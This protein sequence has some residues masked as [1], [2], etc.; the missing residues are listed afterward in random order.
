MTV[1]SNFKRGKPIVQDFDAGAS[2]YAAGDVVVLGDLPCIAH[3]A[4]P[5]YTGGT[6]RDALAIGG[7]IYTVTAES[8]Q[9]KPG[10]RVYWDPTNSRVTANPQSG[11]NCVPFG[12]VVGLGTGL[13]SDAAATATTLDVFHDPTG[14]P[15]GSTYSLGA[16]TNDNITNTSAETA[17]AT[18]AVI[19]SGTLEVGDTIHVRAV[20]L[21]SAQN[22]TNTNTLKLKIT[23]AANTFTA[24]LNTGAVNAA[25]NAVA[26]LDA[27]IVI[28]AVGGSGSFY[29][30]GD[31]AFGASGTAARSPYY[32]ANTGLNTVE[33]I[34]VEVTDTQSAA[35]TGNVTQLVELMVEKLRK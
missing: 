8:A 22:S 34:T 3:S 33:A 20:A 2:T 12:W 28:T 19:P 17:F 21:V 7:G 32:V 10:D 31:I 18:T 6:T 5:S 9:Y 25:A 29:A 16:A 15:A 14:S 27:D 26:I 11:G 30:T 4:I 1:M 35:S 13:L 24:I 23:T